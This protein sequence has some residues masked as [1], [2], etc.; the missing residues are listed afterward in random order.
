MSCINTIKD[1]FFDICEKIKTETINIFNGTTI[2][3]IFD[4]GCAL[5][6]QPTES[7]KETSSKIDK[8]IEQ[9]KALGRTIE[10]SKFFIHSLIEKVKE[11]GRLKVVNKLNNNP[12]HPEYESSFPDLEVIE[13]KKDNTNTWYPSNLDENFDIEVQEGV[14]KVNQKFKDRMNRSIEKSNYNYFMDNNSHWTVSDTSDRPSGKILSAIRDFQKVYEELQS[15]QELNKEF[16]SDFNSSLFIV[17]GNWIHSTKKEEMI[18]T[19]KKLVPNVADQKLI[20]TYAH[21]KILMQSYTELLDEHPELNQY[22]IINSRNSYMITHISNNRIKLVTTNLS[23]VCSKDDHSMQK[24]H[25][26]GVRTSVI[27]SSNN[28]PIMQY[29]YFFE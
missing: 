11:D 24:T 12:N 1:T 23:D 10:S 2:L 6:T 18:E 9:V 7:T 28:S 13:P 25:S 27:L 22:Q 21:P 8:L 17:D 20:S 15:S 26:F 5:F 16:M 4:A 19:F 3:K 29:S 14:L